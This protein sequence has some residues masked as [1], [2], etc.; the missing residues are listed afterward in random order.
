MAKKRVRLL[1]NENETQVTLVKSKSRFKTKA[2]F[3]DI[4]KP[5]QICTYC[6]K[7]YIYPCNG[8]NEMCSN[9]V[10]IDH[11]VDIYSY[12]PHEVEKFLKT[13][14][15]P[16]TT[17]KE[18]LAKTNKNQKKKKKRVRLSKKKKRVRL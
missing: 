12:Y 15:L 4:T 17:I 5:V 3:N 2:G 11:K 7:G 13:G 9:K 6:E 16:K 14:K 10:W 1:E 8:S 18:S